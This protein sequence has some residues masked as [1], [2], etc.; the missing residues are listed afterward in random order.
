MLFSAVLALLLQNALKLFNLLLVFG[1]GTGLIFILRWF[2]WRINAWSEITA[3]FA[4]GI[5]SLSLKL[6]PLG[7]FLFNPA[8]GVFDDYMEYPLV[9]L[10][11]TFIWLFATFVT[12]PESNNVLR[13]F[14]KKIQPGGPGWKRVVDQAEMDNVKIVSNSDQ[15]WSVPSGIK[16]MLLGCITIYSIMFATGYWIYSE[17]TYA[18][19]TTFV[20]IF[21]GYFLYKAWMK[22]KGSVL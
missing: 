3:M 17:F 6:T 12:K 9:V 8:D 21:S 5:V 15:S 13:D 10:V 14:Y 7:N 19:P 1:A 4:S 18:I 11:T 20:A 16:A 22:I 2:W